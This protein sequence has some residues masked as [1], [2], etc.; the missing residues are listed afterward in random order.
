MS[1][2][3]NTGNAAAWH[4]SPRQPQRR[5][6]AWNDRDLPT[7]GRVRH[8]QTDGLAKALVQSRYLTGMSGVD[9]PS[10]ALSR[11]DDAVRFRRDISLARH[12]IH[13]D[14]PTIRQHVAA[15]VGCLSGL[16]L[17]TRRYQRPVV[18]R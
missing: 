18:V 10:L 15:R 11:Y 5:F 9:Y 7:G 3:P 13:D 14:A 6:R 12:G 8:Q 2:C 16:R 1:Q 17:P 4:E